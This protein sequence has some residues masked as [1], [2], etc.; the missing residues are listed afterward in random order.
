MIVVDTSVIAYLLIYGEYSQNARRLFKKDPEWISPYLWR[1]EFRS[2]LSLYMRKGFLSY[3]DSILLMKEAE[4]LLLG[5]EYEVRSETVL[6]IINN[7]KI[8]AY[9]A[10]FIA[11][12]KDLKLKLY[13]SDKSLLKEFPSISRPLSK[14]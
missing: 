1:S 11:L 2:V 13:T 9:D 4:N 8:S 10:E 14:V 3:P 7:S 12:A 6:E 5:M